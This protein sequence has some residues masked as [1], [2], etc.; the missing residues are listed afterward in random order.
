MLFLQAMNAG[1]AEAV[2]AMLRD[3]ALMPA[4]NWAKYWRGADCQACYLAHARALHKVLKLFLCSFVSSMIEM[5][6]NALYC[7]AS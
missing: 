4:A 7:C 1:W 2:P 3:I 5:Q 6:T